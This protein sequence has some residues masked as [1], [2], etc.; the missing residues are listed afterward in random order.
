[1]NKIKAIIFDLGNVLLS[2]ST[3]NSS[4]RELEKD[5]GPFRKDWNSKI[6][7]KNLR[8]L[9]LGKIKEKEFWNIVSKKIK[10][11]NIKKLRQHILSDAKPL[12]AIN[13][14]KQLRKN[15]NLKL[16]LLTD[17]P[18]E[19]LNYYERKY[20]VLHLF[21]VILVSYALHALKTDKRIYKKTIRRIKVKPE[22]VLFIDDKPENIEK[23]KE[24]GINTV[25]YRNIQQ[26]KNK[27][28]KFNI[29][30]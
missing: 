10:N 14:V 6:K 13:L 8:S 12:P 26:L 24:I 11:L 7:N 29:T 16:A 28:K 25:L 22:E 27:L 9:F 21:D 3:S 23:A 1:M 18:E 30:V 15:K 2:D 19:W 4:L 20:K 5:L 17:C